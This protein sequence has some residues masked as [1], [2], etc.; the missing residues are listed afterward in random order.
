MVTAVRVGGRGDGTECVHV[1]VCACVRNGGV[2]R[3][4]IC[5]FIVL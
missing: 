2:A 4:I 1:C 3:F 5:L